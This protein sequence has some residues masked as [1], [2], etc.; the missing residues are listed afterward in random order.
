[1]WSLLLVTLPTQPGAVRLRIWRALKALG[2]AALRDGAYV[3]PA[4]HGA[5]FDEIAD[6]VLRH[7]GTAAVFELGT[8][9]AQQH[10][11]LLAQFSR[12]EAYAR[13]RES[14]EALRGELPSLPE[15][16]ARRKLRT[17]TDALAAVE[18]TDYF[19][20]VSLKQAQAFVATLRRDVDARYSPGEPQPAAGGVARLDR[21][22][23]VGKRWATRAR[24]WVDRLACAWFVRRFIDADARFVW[25]KEPLKLPRGALGF[26]FDGAAFTHVGALVTLEVMAASFGFDG[27]ERLRRVAQAVHFLDVGGIPVA[28]AAGLETILSGLRDLHPDD[29]Q[30]LA[31]ACSVFDALYVAQK[32]AAN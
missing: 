17:L 4:E 26:D 31:A 30:L 24:P 25:L 19:P 13:W 23:F 2:C 5:A 3:L 10:D 6:E 14:G 18:R 20:G 28:D 16:D 8:R 27:D 1:M 12:T 11:D 32:E 7:G 22:R 21:A 9:G 29:D 15:A